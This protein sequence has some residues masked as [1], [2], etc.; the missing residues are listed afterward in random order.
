M[1]NVN[2]CNNCERRK[3]E[4]NEY[5]DFVNT[6]NGKRIDCNIFEERPSWCPLDNGYTYTDNGDGTFTEE[7]KSNE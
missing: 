3:L 2:T 6:C 5:D 7:E 4:I 1:S